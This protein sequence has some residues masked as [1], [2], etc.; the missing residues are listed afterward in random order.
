M[1]ILDSSVWKTHAW[2]T[3]QMFLDKFYCKPCPILLW[4]LNINRETS[5]QFLG[6]LSSFPP[7][8]NVPVSQLLSRAPQLVLISWTDWLKGHPPKQLFL[9][10]IPKGHNRAKNGA[11]NDYK[12]LIHE[13]LSFEGNCSNRFNSGWIDHCS[14][15]WKQSPRPTVSL[16][17]GTWG[18]ALYIRHSFILW[19]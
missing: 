1:W 5:Q 11:Q 10:F 19:A 4:S 12:A 6:S 3:S 7:S 9:H 17:N 18:Q 2:R 15:K 13:E 14:R 16:L 8:I